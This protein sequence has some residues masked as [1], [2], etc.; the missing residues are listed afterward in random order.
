MSPLPDKEGFTGIMRS[1]LLRSRL[2]V[3]AECVVMLGTV[4]VFMALVVVEGVV[5]VFD[6]TFGGGARAGG[7]LAGAVG[8]AVREEGASHDLLGK[9][10]VCLALGR[11]V[12]GA[13]L[14]LTCDLVDVAL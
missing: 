2:V 7:A 3:I 5:G 13:G 6:T 1:S 8:V 14:A 10:G 11:L 4:G 9:E 12:L